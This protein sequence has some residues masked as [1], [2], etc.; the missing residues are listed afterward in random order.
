MTLRT[1]GLPVG[2]VISLGLREQGA[3]EVLKQLCSVDGLKS[4]CMWVPS[5]YPSPDCTW[6]VM[7]SFLVSDTRLS[8]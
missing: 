2:L 7:G 4:K 5:S 6:L 3:T 8:P 1:H